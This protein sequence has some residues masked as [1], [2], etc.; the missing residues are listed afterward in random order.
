MH[1]Q[2]FPQSVVRWASFSS[3]GT[4]FP[5]VAVGG[6]LFAL[7]GLCN[8]ILYAV[9]RPNLLRADADTELAALHTAAPPHASTLGHA[10]TQGHLPDDAAAGAA[11][12]TAVLR[13]PPP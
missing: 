1:S 9:T 12:W 6:T 11:H 13:P 5:A 3:W 2:V 4:T 8:T 10:R 7:S